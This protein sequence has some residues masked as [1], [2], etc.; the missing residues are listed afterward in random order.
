MNIELF[1]KTIN[2]RYIIH[3]RRY[4]LLSVGLAIFSI[5][6]IIFVIV[7]QAQVAWER[8]GELQ[9]EQEELADLE[10]K[11]LQ[12][13][14]LPQSDLFQRADEINKLLPARKPLLELLSALNEVAFSS[15][16][17]Y[18]DLSLSPGKIASGGADLSEAPAQPGSRRTQPTNASSRGPVPGVEALS[19]QL[20]VSGS[21]ENIS[22][23]LRQVEQ[24]A[25]LTTVTQLSLV[26][27]AATR[28]NP[29]SSFEAELEVETYFFTR[30]ISATLAAPLPTLNVDQQL[31]LNQI[32]DYR[33]PQVLTRD[34]IQ[35]GGS[36]DPFGVTDPELITQ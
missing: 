1:G 26:E 14:Q 35:G 27:R 2:Y 4:A 9:D 20:K 30:S 22:D 10:N 6:L 13:Q 33:Y 19:I 23:F 34:I 18:S 21:L 31:L 24:V 12:L 32:Q 5:C 36:L 17:L 7:P 15:N 25:P 29:E 16:I 11:S 3:T 28:T 8:F